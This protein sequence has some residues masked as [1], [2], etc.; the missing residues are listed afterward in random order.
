MSDN[1]ILDEISIKI[2]GILQKNSRLTFS[3][4]GRQIGLS[5][6]AVAERVKKMEDAEIIKRYSIEI[7]HSKMGLG[8]SAF[9]L[10]TLGGNM[11]PFIMKVEEIIKDVPEVLECHRVT[12]REDVI[13]KMV[14]SSIPH[15]KKVIDSIAPLGELN[16][17][18]I[19]T[20]SRET[21]YIDIEKFFTQYEPKTQMISQYIP[22]NNSIRS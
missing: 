19:V 4:I 11:S 13:I 1:L 14:F 9:I 12:G 2:L 6:P 17:C 22:K 20:S 5:S 10:V 15:L 8:M 16:T 7:D 18:I 3:E 21:S